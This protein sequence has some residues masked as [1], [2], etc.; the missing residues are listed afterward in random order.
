MPFKKPT[1]FN[2][3]AGHCK[4]K[5]TLPLGVNALLDADKNRL[6]IEGSATI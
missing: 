6:I 1:I 2:L 5:V 3:K 4:P